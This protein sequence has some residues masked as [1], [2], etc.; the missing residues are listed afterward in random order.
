[1]TA[2]TGTPEPAREQ[3]ALSR[4]GDKDLSRRAEKSVPSELPP[5]AATFLSSPS[6][7]FLIIITIIIFELFIII[8]SSGEAEAQARCS[9]SPNNGGIKRPIAAVFKSLFTRTL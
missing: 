1:M 9:I 6:R 5:A 7:L 3:G 2:G 4:A 8:S